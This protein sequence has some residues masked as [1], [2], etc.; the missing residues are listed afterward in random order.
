MYLTIRINN[1]V[2]S[3]SNVSFNE[4]S[5][6][7]AIGKCFLKVSCPCSLIATLDNGESVTFDLK[8]GTTIYKFGK[9]YNSIKAICRSNT[10]SVSPSSYKECFLTYI[11]SENNRY[12]FFHLYE[13]CTYE[14]GRLGTTGNSNSFP[15]YLYWIKYYEKI[16]EGYNDLSKVYLS[17]KI[18]CCIP[19][20]VRKN[21]ASSSASMQL[22]FTLKDLSENYLIKNLSSLSVTKGQYAESK[23]LIAKLSEYANAKDIYGFNET[24][25]SL[26]SILPRNVDDVVDLVAHSRKDYEPIIQREEN[27]LHSMTTSLNL[28]R[29]IS[30]FDSVGISIEELSDSDK[31]N[32][33]NSLSIKLP[34]TR[35]YS[36]SHKKQNTKFTTYCKSKAISHKSL[37]F[38]GSTDVNWF[39]ILLN[40][41]MIAPSCAS[42]HGSAC[43]LGCYFSSD[44]SESLSYSRNPNKK[45][46]G[47]FEVA[48][49]KSL[50]FDLLP[51]SCTNINDS[52]VNSFNCNSFSCNTRTIVYNESACCIRYLLEI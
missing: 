35:V 40:S 5:I 43:G 24:L 3:K 26:L 8:K 48:V 25:E 31:E 50:S 21:V 17:S 37:L 7:K 51:S 27:I 38:H 32:L 20:R 12:S 28:N 42:F 13:D 36:V 2:F 52:L 30:S 41:L 16:S 22:F 9:P 45:Y 15:S 4:S 6:F 14:E 47:V 49:G 33:L 23:K 46:V 11:S 10:I 19:R 34:V 29:N 18:N 39:S 1:K 44:L